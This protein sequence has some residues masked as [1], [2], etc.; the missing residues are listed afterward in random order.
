MFGVLRRSRGRNARRQS[1]A[2]KP[3]G[4]VQLTTTTTR[5]HDVPI[6][7]AE[8]IQVDTRG[9]VILTED[10]PAVSAPSPLSC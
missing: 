4:I 1:G 8:A 6:P 5:M 9:A 2:E 3:G 10:S 7:T